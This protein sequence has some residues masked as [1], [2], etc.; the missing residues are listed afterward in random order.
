[1]QIN[2]A[3]VAAMVTIGIAA[4]SYAAFNTDVLIHRAK[5]V[6]GAADCRSVDSAIVAYVAGHGVA[7]TSIDQIKRYVRGDVSRYRIVEGK[8]V[9]PGCP[10]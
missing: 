10:A 3:A 9:G 8:A 4:A 5:V 6:A 7:P 1:V 2:E